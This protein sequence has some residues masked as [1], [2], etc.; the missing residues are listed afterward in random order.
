LEDP[1]T[2]SAWID[3]QGPNLKGPTFLRK[4][5]S[6]KKKKNIKTMGPKSWEF[7]PSGRDAVIKT[8]EQWMDSKRL[9]DDLG[10]GAN[11]I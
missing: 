1:S 9:D 5:Q 4:Q 11:A 6:P 7:Y 3:G 2:D 8:S 10:P